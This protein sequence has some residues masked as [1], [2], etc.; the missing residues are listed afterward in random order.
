[1]IRIEVKQISG[2]TVVRCLTSK[3]NDEYAIQEW[4]DELTQAAESVGKAF[5]VD[6]SQV[7]FMSSSALR[8][9]ITLQKTVA[10]QNVPLLLCGL[11]DSI[12]EIFKITNLDSIFKIRKG[13]EEA[14]RSLQYL[15]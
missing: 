8:A 7:M 2:C 9:L 13:T 10:L 11:N 12:L 6:F 5:V 1:M 14:I 4:G 3:L 15:E